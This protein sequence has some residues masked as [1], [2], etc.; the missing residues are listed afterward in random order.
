MNYQTL[1][2]L[3]VAAAVEVATCAASLVDPSL[4]ECDHSKETLQ[5]GK[6]K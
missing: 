1:I 5:L 3:F 2:N 4:V 6:R